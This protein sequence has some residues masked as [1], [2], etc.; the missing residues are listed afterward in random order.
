MNATRIIGTGL[1]ALLAGCAA[2]PPPEA[3]PLWVPAAAPKFVTIGR[4]TTYALVHRAG[5]DLLI[6]EDP[7]VSADGS[8]VSG[9]LTWIA[10]VPDV[11]EF[12]KPIEVGGRSSEAWLLEQLDGEQSHATP[13]SGS[14][15]IHHRDS[16]RLS[17]TLNLRALG[18]K[19]TAGQPERVTIDL[20][21]RFDFARY[22]PTTPRYKEMGA[23][24]GVGGKA[25]R[26]E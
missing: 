7:L 25:R 2:S 22:T 3:S 8:V 13:A 17:A 15:T 26:A 5:Q 24:S 23:R 10:P 20:D 16:Q 1:L 14:V 19:P 11:A 21:R 9:R 4:S 18:P 12:D 6:V